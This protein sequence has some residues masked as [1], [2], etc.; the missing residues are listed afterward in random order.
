MQHKLTFE[1]ELATLLKSGLEFED[2]QA[3]VVEL[4]HKHGRKVPPP[5]EGTMTLTEKPDTF[6]GG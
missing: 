5:I 1:E 4:H 2:L 6:G 3:E